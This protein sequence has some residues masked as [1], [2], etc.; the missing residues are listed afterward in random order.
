MKNT[1]KNDFYEADFSCGNTAKGICKD[2]DT[3]VFMKRWHS[4]NIRAKNEIDIAGR[5]ES[6]SVC[7]FSDV[8]AEEGMTYAVREW[9]DAVSLAEFILKEKSLPLSKALDIMIKICAALRDIAEKYGDFVHADIRPSNF[10]YDIKSKQIWFIDL[11]TVTFLGENDVKRLTG[12]LQRGGY[13]VSLTSAG[14]TAPEVYKGEICLQSDVFS[15][16]KLFAF[17]LGLCNH[18]GEIIHTKNTKLYKE[19]MPIIKKCI[20]SDIGERYGSPAVMLDELC[21][22]F[23]S[24]SDDIVPAES[25]D[26][27]ENLSDKIIPFKK[28]EV[29]IKQNIPTLHKHNST[30][31]YVADNSCF[32]S[33]LS[34][35][36]A[37]HRGLK[38]L[39]LETDSSIGIGAFDYFIDRHS[40]ISSSFV[41]EQRNPF[42]CD[43]RHLYL[44]DENQWVLRGI[45]SKSRQNE[46]LYVSDCNVFSEFDI[47]DVNDVK[48][49]FDWSNRYFDMTIICDSDGTSDTLSEK[50]MFNTD[51]IIVPVRPNIDEVYASFKY[52]R[53]QYLKYSAKIP[54]IV[55]VAWEY[56]EGISMPLNDFRIAVDNLYAGYIPYDSERLKCKNIKGNFF[57]EQYADELYLSYNTLF[58]RIF[59]L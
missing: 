30:V 52:Y 11:E 18:D 21:N 13:T 47:S 15:L 58:D 32:A 28:N 39:L 41:C 26:R 23:N 53:Q 27:S 25:L 35:L 31:V 50:I 6:G 14:F 51:Y 43:C 29:N 42:F 48:S 59:T 10:L 5:I 22:L 3:V 40:D 34:Y 57:C 38:T 7:P 46:N 17:L 16:G 12:L 8:F 1:Y 36:A 20:S 49:L 56:E 37:S 44:T 4:E 54:D 45:L 33:E 24:L 2:S 9:I 19:A 55:F